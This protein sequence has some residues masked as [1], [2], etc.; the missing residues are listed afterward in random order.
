MQT[1]IVLVCERCNKEFTRRKAEHTRNQKRGRK[2]FCGRRC[3]CAD[4][5]NHIPAHKVNR[6]ASHLRDI[7]RTDEYS[8]FRYHLANAKRHS[9]KISKGR[10]CT[11]T[12]QDLKEVWDRQNGICPYTGWQIVNPPSTT[13]TTRGGGIQFTKAPNR[14][15]LDRID[16]SKGYI[17][18]NIQFVALIANVAKNDFT[19]DALIDFCKAVV[20]YR[21]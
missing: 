9:A 17:K 20:E 19:D 6:N 4:N 5:I 15:S 8:P 1:E 3:Q 10:E 2:V 13:F 18:G 12:L 16:V 14:A 21:K 11:I 7:I